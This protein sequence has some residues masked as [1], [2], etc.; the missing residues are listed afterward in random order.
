[1]PRF[2]I[3]SLV[4]GAVLL[5]GGITC[6]REHPASVAEPA[7]A[8]R[9]SSH[10]TAPA[11]RMKRIGVLYWS[12]TI[13]G[14]RAMRRGV[15]REA[16]RLTT[17]GAR[18]ELVPFVAGDGADGKVRQVE[19]MAALIDARVDGILVQP[20]DNIVLGPQ[21]RR[22]NA[23]GIPVVAWDQYIEEGTLAAFVTSDNAQAGRL[24]G[25]YIANRFPAGHNIRL[26][27][28]EYPPVSSTVERL[29]AFLAA[30][31]RQGRRHT[32]VATYEAVEPVAGAHAGAQLLRDFPQRGSVDAVFTVNDGGGLAVVEALKAAGRTEILV[33]T[34]DGDP[35]SVENI[36]SGTVTVIDAAQFCGPLG[37]AAMHTMWQ[38]LEGK[39]VPRRRLVSTFPVTAE[40][41]ARYPG[42][43]G[44]LPAPFT[45]PWPSQTAT[46][47]AGDAL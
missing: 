20:T 2:A 40:T 35:K 39:P 30:L 1:M 24:D 15:E 42:W 28:V 32:I 22:A 11:T 45:L 23:A 13:E 7:D 36:R 31:E 18:F 44:P 41:L 26:V 37:E 47:T 33:A 29:D 14:Q 38:V 17:S 46:W 3:A 9:T 10:D 4:F 19:Q 16:Q 34:V 27:L 21:L 8:Q 12:A 43:D 25:E 5:V 6:Q